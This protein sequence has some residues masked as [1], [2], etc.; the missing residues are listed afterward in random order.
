MSMYDNLRELLKVH[1]VT[2]E[3]T[4]NQLDMFILEAKLLIDAPFINNNQY[5]EYIPDFNDDIYCTNEYPLITDSVELSVDNQVVTPEHIT[6]DGLIYLDHVYQ[7]TLRCNYVTGL[8]E[9]E[10]NTDLLPVVACLIEEKEGM[11]IASVSEG[12]INISYNTS[13]GYTSNTLD[14]LIQQI[15]DKYSGAR[16][17]LI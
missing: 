13:N 17:R 16:V 5:E 2:K 10:I 12:D 15:R 6:A 14:T 9:D 4:D 11:N 1:G 3:Y 7:G 8:N